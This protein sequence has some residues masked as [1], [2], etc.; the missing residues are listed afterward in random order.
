MLHP[1]VVLLTEVVGLLI[2]NLELLDEQSYTTLHIFW[3]KPI[4]HSLASQLTMAAWPYGLQLDGC[5]IW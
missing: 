3:L 2:L 1:Y 4:A 5:R